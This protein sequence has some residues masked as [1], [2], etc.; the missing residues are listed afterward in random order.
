MIQHLD[1]TLRQILI[2]TGIDPNVINID[3]E[4]PSEEWETKLSRLTVNCFL[5]DIRENLALRFDQQRYLERDRT[6][7]KETV[8]PARIDFTYLITVWAMKSGG[9]ITLVRDEHR[10]LGRILQTLLRYP[11]LPPELLQGDLQQQPYPVRA[12]I[13]Q[14]EDVPKVWEFWG[15]NQWRLKAGLSYRVTVA[16]DPMEPVEVD[17]VTESVL[18]AE[19]MPSSPG[20]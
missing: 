6:T 4:R 14:P 1:E 12:W 18:R 20:G 2:E 9:D 13:A 16:I 8:A 10:L 3:F 7:G 19:S 5:Y 15:A 17:L 11:I